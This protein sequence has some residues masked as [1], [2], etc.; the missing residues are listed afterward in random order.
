[1][2][3]IRY[4]EKY[5]Y[6]FKRNL[7]YTYK[8]YKNNKI[9]YNSNIY[10]NILAE[11]NKEGDYTLFQFEERDIE[12][13]RNDYIIDFPENLLYK[14]FNSLMIFWDK[15]NFYC[16]IF[17]INNINEK[18]NIIEEACK[19]EKNLLNEIKEIKSIVNNEDD[20][21]Y[22]INENRIIKSLFGNLYFKNINF[23]NARKVFFLNNLIG[24]LI[25][26][27]EITENIF[28]NKV[29]IIGKIAMD[30]IEET[31][32][33]KLLS[34]IVDL[35]VENFEFLYKCT[36]LIKED[37]LKKVNSESIMTINNSFEL[38]EKNT[39]CAEGVE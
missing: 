18:I 21:F 34:K 11:G 37:F 2:K 5:K 26:P 39:I 13:K 38:K 16:K 10:L 1:M 7:Y 6:Q 32:F 3:L 29:E 28:E 24:N 14:I 20:F 8:R 35:K 31:L 33:I 22:F 19:N 15:E 25:L 9:E 30:M 17:N 23:S 4:R 27:I 36:L 12:I